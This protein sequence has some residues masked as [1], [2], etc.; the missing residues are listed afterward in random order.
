MYLD[1]G[2]ETV[3]DLIKRI[4]LKPDEVSQPVKDAKSSLQELLQEGGGETPT[5]ETLSVKGPSHA[6]EFTVAVFHQ[7]HEL[8]RGSAGSKKQAAQ[9]AAQAALDRLRK[10]K[11][12]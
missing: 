10:E 11:K 12:A 4:W 5:Y 8:A 1:G 7:G 2:L 3:R 9:V 6:P